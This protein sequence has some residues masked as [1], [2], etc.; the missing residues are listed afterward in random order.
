MA[1]HDLPARPGP[2]A[3]HVVVESPRGAT[4][5]LKYEPALGAM[6]VARPLPVGLVYPYD[7]GFVPGTRAV[8]GDPLDAMV[9]WETPTYPGV[10]IEG[11]V[12][13]VVQLEQNG[14]GPD[15][16]PLGRE[17]ND[18]VIVA[19]LKARRLEQLKSVYELPAR[20]RKELE[21]FFIAVV[22][23]QNKD[24]R[25]IGWGGPSEAEAT[26]DAAMRAVKPPRRR[27]K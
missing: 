4:V 16:R 27:S 23:S 24:P 13:G 17:R 14:K 26:I 20:L 25:I 22:F 18:R 2:G 10:V 1:L 19:P 3:V 7:W 12:I 8:D 9:L 11:R 5:K 6:V 15:G 21:H